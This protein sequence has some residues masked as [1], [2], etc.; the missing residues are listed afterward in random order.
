VSQSGVGELSQSELQGLLAGKT[1]QVV[2]GIY[3]LSEDFSGY[4]TAQDL[5]LAFQ[6]IYLYAT[7]PRLDP[8][9]VQVYQNQARAALINRTVTPYAA[10]QDALVDALYGDT[11]RRGPLPLEQIERFDPERALAIYRDRFADMSD[12]TFTFVGNVDEAEI[13]RLAQRYLGAL[14]GGGRQES[15]RDAAPMQWSDVVERTVVKGQEEQSLVQMVF[16]GPISV[17][18]ESAVQLDALEALL[19][20]RLR[21]DLR[22]ARSGIYTPFVSSDLSSA[23]TPRYQM[24]IEFGA[25][26]NRV[27]ELVGALFDQISDLQENGPSPAELA[28]VQEQLRRNRQ[29]ALRDNDFWLWTIEQHF[30]T[31]GESPDGILAY[32]RQLEALQ[33]ADLQAA[34]T[35]FLPQDR[36]VRITLYPEG[37]EPKN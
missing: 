3:E 13:R 9:A 30:T 10:M 18:Q 23:P 8:A 22:E 34:A 35:R 5:E 21:D 6:L 28:K 36:Y 25:D 4:T 37:F 7:E 33:P 24:W 26:P 1:A 19:T 15:G 16:S 27:D 32:D 11:L 31:P 12:F 17:T 2:P 20:I 29:E 14:P